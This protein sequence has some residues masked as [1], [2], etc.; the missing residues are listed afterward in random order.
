MQILPLTTKT[1][2]SAIKLRDSIFKNI[3]INE[4]NTLNASLFKNNFKD[5][6]RINNLAELSY[7]VVTN[8]SNN[9]VSGFQ[10]FLSHQLLVYFFL[11]FSWIYNFNICA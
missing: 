3:P 10:D 11:P 9:D 6:Y 2:P 7:F 5:T 1:L 8:P 4:V